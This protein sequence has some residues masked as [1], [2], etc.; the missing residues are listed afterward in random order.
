MKYKSFTIAAITL[1]HS[2]GYSEICLT[3][4]GQATPLKT[5]AA[6]C[7][8]SIT[9]LKE[10]ARMGDGQ[11]YLQLARCYHDGFGVE[12]DFLA[13]WTM[14]KMAVQYGAISR[15]EDFLADYAPDDPDRILMEAMQDT[16]RRHSKEILK[17][18]E[19]LDS[20]NKAYAA[21]IK[22][23]LAL[24]DN[25]KEE[26]MDLLR[27][28]SADGCVLADMAIALNER[29]S[30]AVYDFADRMP[31]LY[32]AIARGRITTDFSPAEEEQVAHYY[33][34]ADEHLC[35]DDIGVRWLHGYYEHR[36]QTDSL[37]VDSTE[38]HRLRILR[39]KLARP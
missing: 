17:K 30:E 3:T 15:S 14:A 7:Q 10:Q 35:L 13:M 22:G 11:A 31:M 1:L 8:D 29:G 23:C 32:C 9:I 37:S 28:A 21:L 38:L 20:R 34:L 5:A 39:E 33:R 16:G 2:L 27:L 24:T 18:T 36:A 6:A 4:D 12:H 19:T 26:A 25:R